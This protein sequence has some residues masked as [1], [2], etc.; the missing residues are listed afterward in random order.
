M[1]FTGLTAALLLTM[2]GG[3][4]AQL[5]DLPGGGFNSPQS[6]ATQGRIRS[7]ADDALRPD[8][9]RNVKF[10]KWFGVVSFSNLFDAKA[11]LGFATNIG[12]T[13]FSTFYRGSFWENIPNESYKKVGLPFQG[14]VKAFPVYDSTFD[15][16]GYQPNNTIG[17]LVGVADM[18]FRLSFNSRYRS[19]NK[20]NI[21]IGGGTGTDIYKTY[22][23]A[24]GNLHPQLV[25]SMAKNLTKDG[26]RPYAGVDLIFANYYEKYEQY[27]PDTGTTDGEKVV[28]SKNYIEPRL[29]VGMGGYT[30]YNQNGFSL[31]TD[32]EYQ[33][34]LKLINNEYSYL[35][36]EKY[37]IQKIKG[38]NTS[39]SLTENSY[40]Y[41][42]LMPALAGSWAK[43]NLTLRF[44]LRLPVSLTNEEETEMDGSTG[45]LVK[46][47]NY[48]KTTT[49]SFAPQLR[50]A[51]RWVIVPQ[52]AL[53]AGGSITALPVTYQYIDGDN[54]TVEEIM[55]G[56]VQSRLSLG[57]TF[58]ATDKL[59]FDAVCG[60]DSVNNSINVFA[61]GNNGLFYFGNILVSLRF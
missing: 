52:L 6:E 37:R 16:V 22:Q 23:K 43:D 56:S 41:N 24:T 30:L 36:G 51:A 11:M 38:Y 15:L 4:W 1:K 27:D 14:G 60:V 29:T 49:F 34:H 31:S 42:S 55:Y 48:A 46:D 44:Q 33:L 47:G 50:L 61:T 8:A 45:S 9:Y 59:S 25:W 19:F 20:D 21:G 57:A 18:G 32:M 40:I 3:L 13:Y 58:N 54:Y 53:N 7:M 35:E 28:T 10:E 39:G 2:T 5:I 26:I 17:V 12:S